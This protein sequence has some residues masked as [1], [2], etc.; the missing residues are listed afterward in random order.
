MMVNLQAVTSGIRRTIYTS[1]TLLGILAAIC[2]AALM[3]TVVADT[4][5]RFVFL[6]PIPGANDYSRFWWMTLIVFGGLGLA[7][8]R[9]EHIEALVLENR[10]PPRLRAVWQGIRA[11][12]ITITLALLLV[13]AIPSAV[14]HQ[15]QGEYAPGSEIAIWPTR[16][17]L[18]L[19]AGVFLLTA[20]TRA[21]QMG[22]EYRQKNGEAETSEE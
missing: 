15:A 21:L 1:A 4:T 2:V 7:E 22:R 3:I 19:G 20:I 13:A 18:I 8:R 17:V 6:T 9:N 14:G 16:Y 10:M 12:V 11:F 5:G